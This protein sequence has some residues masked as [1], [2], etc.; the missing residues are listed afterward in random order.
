M[1]GLSVIHWA[2]RYEN[3]KKTSAMDVLATSRETWFTRLASSISGSLAAA[4]LA[5]NLQS[6]RHHFIGTM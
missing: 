2:N 5:V 6:W 1:R 4:S 3:S